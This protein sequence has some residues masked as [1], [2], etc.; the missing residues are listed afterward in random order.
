M[1]FAVVV[2][3]I[4]AATVGAGAGIANAA[5]TDPQ[6]PVGTTDGRL[7]LGN[8][9]A[10]IEGLES[11][12][13]RNPTAT[14]AAIRLGELL[15]ERGRFTG[16]I[17]DYGQ[18]ERIAVRLAA[19]YPK[20][21]AVRLLLARTHAV[22]H[23][24]DSAA[25]EIKL[26][27][28]SG[29]VAR[30]P[31]E[32]L[33]ASILEARGEIEA[34]RA[35]RRGERVG[36]PA[37]AGLAALASLQAASGDWA[38]AAQL[39]ARARD[40]YRGTSPFAL[41]AIHYEEGRMWVE[42]EELQRARA[43]LAHAVRLVPDYAPALGHLAEVEAELGDRARAIVILQKIASRSDDPDYAAQLARILVDAG[44]AA[45]A[46]PWKEQAEQRFE[47]LMGKYPEAFADHAAEFWLAAGANPARALEAARFNQELRATSRASE[48]LARA[49][50]CVAATP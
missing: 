45:E 30:V 33:E 25:A 1:A 28:S 39:F 43:S 27:C 3:A 31:C 50:R 24:F 42:A 35:L 19:A 40:A 17:A 13:V 2:A 22:F 6:V 12:I 15:I 4:S 38:G 32:A 14:G 48:L 34:A 36:N 5:N 46:Q 16:T 23:R 11:K 49:E 47:R 21:A 26:A 10:E 44:R 29:R 7:A 37:S 8:L 41:A 20:S 18:A 9:S